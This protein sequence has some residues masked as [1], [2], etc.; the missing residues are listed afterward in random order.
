MLYA[1][2]VLEDVPS[3]E[4]TE[5]VPGSSEPH[6]T[7]C[8]DP[9]QAWRSAALCGE[10]PTE[11]NRS[12]RDEGVVIDVRVF[13]PEIFDAVWP[14]IVSIRA[15]R[16]REPLTPE[17]WRRLWL[18]GYAHLRRCDPD[19]YAAT[20]GGAA[21]AIAVLA[22]LIR[23]IEVDFRDSAAA[24]R[25]SPRIPTWTRCAPSAVTLL[26]WLDS[27]ASIRARA[28]RTAWSKGDWVTCCAIP[29]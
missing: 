26:R 9:S 2:A 12:D 28:S 15:D 20:P 22:P 14:R 24:N 8:R 6:G 17:A 16:A 10:L 27:E 7:D 25:L 3:V 23:R 13:R 29:A 18:N 19:V 5:F 21:R 4:D 1:N 11:I